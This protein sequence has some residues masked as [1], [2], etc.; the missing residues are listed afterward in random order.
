[1][2]SALERIKIKDI[3]L[4]K[5]REIWGDLAG[6]I[7]SE[8]TSALL[9]LV[10]LLVILAIYILRTNMSAWQRIFVFLTVTVVLSSVALALVWAIAPVQNGPTKSE[11][12]VQAAK[13]APQN[14]ETIILTASDAIELVNT[15]VGPLPKVY[16]VDVLMN[17]PPFN[18][19][20]NSAAFTVNATAAGVYLLEI[21]KADSDPDPKG[22][23][24]NVFVDDVLRLGP[25]A[26]GT[27]GGWGQA[28]QTWV[29]AG[30]LNLKE[31]V[32]TVKLQRDNVFP[33]ITAL[34]FIKQ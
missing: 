6:N 16:G 22:R 5:L 10:L 17:A 13:E 15:A 3:P 8:L 19:V 2:E 30:L 12:V 7:Q 32:N 1:M 4:E 33:H 27:T 21:R 25:V 18:A 28:H 24:L 9:I 26:G 14:V 34:R 20:E 29:E 11:L 23:P 31:G